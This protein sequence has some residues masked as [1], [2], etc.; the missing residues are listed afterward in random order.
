M[1][2]KL[3]VMRENTVKPAGLKFLVSE[4][5]K[6]AKSVRG[7]QRRRLF[8][9]SDFSKLSG[10]NTSARKPARFV[11]VNEVEYALSLRLA[12]ICLIQRT[13]SLCDG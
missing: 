12:F 8:Q 5:S 11:N 4:T 6:T 7:P 2:V 1:V 9:P 10:R 13:G 3:Q